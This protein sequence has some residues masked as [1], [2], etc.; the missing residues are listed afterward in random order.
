MDKLWINKNA[1]T[2]LLVSEGEIQL[3]EGYKWITYSNNKE[4]IK[5]IREFINKEFEG[6]KY[7][8]EHISYYFRGGA[9]FKGIIGD[10]GILGI[11]SV[12]VTMMRIPNEKSN[13]HKPELHSKL[14]SEINFLSITKP[15]RGKGF[16]NLLVK[17][18]IRISV[19]KG[20]TRGIYT[21]TDRHKNV[22]KECH[23]YHYL[24]NIRKLVDIGFIEDGK[25][26]GI[27]KLEEILKV[28][29]GV[30]KINRRYKLSDKIIEKLNK[31]VEKFDISKKYGN[32]DNSEGI[33]NLKDEIFEYYTT[34]GTDGNIKALL[35]LYKLDYVREQGNIKNAIIYTYYHDTD[36]KLN[37]FLKS[38][39]YEIKHFDCISCLDIMDITVDLLNELRMKEGSDVN[40]Y[41]FDL[42]N[43]GVSSIKKI[44][45]SNF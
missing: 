31:Y 25:T 4:N 17:E 22:I 33:E 8:D 39:F 37:E 29:S 9:I 3:P 43:S 16:I 41:M 23:Y 35:V 42:T 2:E 5:L 1:G 21:S 6:I 28:N 34:E 24:S 38:C 26:I 10:R 12:K 32:K 27:E 11:I 14:V 44:G 20:V 7:T 13:T 19:N 40:Y 30:Y 18:V 45:N 36:I 15:Y